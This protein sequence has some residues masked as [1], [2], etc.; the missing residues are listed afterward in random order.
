[1]KNFSDLNCAGKM[2]ARN[3][4]RIAVLLPLAALMGRAAAQTPVKAPFHFSGGTLL[5]G[6]FGAGRLAQFDLNADNARSTSAGGT[7]YPYAIVADPDN[8]LLVSSLDSVQKFNGKT[9]A[10]MGAFVKAGSGGLSNATGMKYGPDGNLYVV[11]GD[12]KTGRVLRYNGK[13]GEFLGVF[14]NEEESGIQLPTDIVFGRDGD[15][16]VVDQTAG[17]VLRFKG[18]TGEFDRVFASGEMLISPRN[19]TFGPDG[20]LYVSSGFLDGSGSV[21][22]FDGSTGLYRDTF[23]PNNRGGLSEAAG[24]TFGSDGVLYV[25]SEATNTVLGFNGKTGAFLGAV[26][27]T[28]GTP[29]GILFRSAPPLN[30]GALAGKEK[31]RR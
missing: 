26:G 25:V 21:V 22:R 6:E 8:N 7:A 4:R 14:I 1:M 29:Y 3:F 12:S 16:Y 23:V 31:P 15:A 13:T 24:L 19:L 9:G 11:T 27:T 20:N 10:A 2:T 17:E 18:K 28:N 5:I 30:A